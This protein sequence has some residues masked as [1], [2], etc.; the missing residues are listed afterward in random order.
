MGPRDAAGPPPARPHG[1]R[2]RIRALPWLTRGAPWWLLGGLGVLLVAAGLFLLTRPLSALGVLGVYIGVSCVVSGVAD[3]L[4]PPDRARRGFH[5]LE[6]WWWIAAGVA[7]LAWLGRDVDLLGPAVAALLL[8]SGAIAL[9]GLFVDRSADAWIRALFGVAEII[10]GLLAL[11]WPD[12]TLIVIAVLFGG[13]T[14]VFGLMLIWRGVHAA[15][16]W[17]RTRRPQRTALRVVVAVSVLVLALVTAWVSHSLR[18]GA[19]VVDAFYDTPGTLPTEPGV[20]IRTAPYDGNLPVGL[21]GTRIYYTTTNADGMIVPS[22]GLLAVP[23]DNADPGTAPAPLITW[24]HGTVGVARACAPSINPEAITVGGIP[25][26]DRLAELG[27]AMVATDYPGMGAEGDFPYLIGQGEGR[28]TL[29]A[30][31]AARQI[32]GVRLAPETVIWGHSQGGHAALWAGQLAVEYAPDLDVVGTAALS[33][34]SNPRALAESVLAHP[35]ALGA[36]LGVSF[37]VRSYAAYY[38][39][40]P[41]DEVVAP[42]AR[43]IVREAAARCTGQGATLV[44]ALTGLTIAADQPIVNPDALNGRFGER[45]TENIPTGPWSAP[46]FIGQG[47]SDEVIAFRINQDYVAGLCATGTDVD[48]RGYPGGTHMSVLA[49]GSDLN[50]D[51]VAWTQDRLAGKP[52]PS[53]CPS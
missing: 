24:A 16:G 51:L 18:G 22:S 14:L 42:A 3:L 33:P 31:R 38:P 9:A 43:S 8:G 46:L 6:P 1:W 39:D 28:A 32:P 26:A 30:A 13:R 45:L 21:V 23:A 15:L 27:W 48:F 29:D 2:E 5:R 7:V 49:A 17:S 41:F 34:A 47:E 36:S 10:F 40:L 25:A 35:E 19:P 12:A 50:A 44:T 4:A 11:L 37:V 52:A 20:L 53:T